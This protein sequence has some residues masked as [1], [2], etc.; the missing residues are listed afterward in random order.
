MRNKADENFD[1][2]A[3]MFQNAVTESIDENGEVARAIDKGALMQEIFCK[4]V[5]GRKER[6]Q[7]T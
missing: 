3:A 5:E 2:L 1:K 4:V 7:F 6:Y